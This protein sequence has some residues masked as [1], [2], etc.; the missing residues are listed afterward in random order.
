MVRR[1]CR[2]E[3]K[4]N[5]GTHSDRPSKGHRLGQAFP[6]DPFASHRP[7]HQRSLLEIIQRSF[8]MDDVIVIVLQDVRVSTE[9]VC[10][11]PDQRPLLLVASLEGF[12]E[13]RMPFV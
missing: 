12:R 7:F 5:L 11:A 9:D 4:V 2:G 6:L 10:Q 13:E 3:G 8:Q 1:G